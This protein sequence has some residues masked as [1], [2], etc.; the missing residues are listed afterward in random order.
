VNITSVK[1]K[2]N[3]KAKRLNLSP[4]DLM[5]MYFFERILYRIS[6]SEYKYN[7]IIKGGLLLSSMFEDE[8]RTTQDMDAMLKGIEVSKENLEKV[9]SDI[10]KIDVEDGITFEILDFRKIREE[11][12]YGGYRV[13]IKAFADKLSINLKMDIT[14]GDPI[15]PRE[16][17]YSYKC[18]ID[19]GTIKIMAF[20]KYSVIAEKFETL[21][22]TLETDTRAKDFYDIYKLMSD[23]IDREKVYKAIYS[24][25]KRR[26][27]LNLLED[28]E[29]R[30]NIIKE[31]TALKEYWHNYQ[32][33]NYYAKNVSYEDFTNSVEDIINIIISK[34]Q[35]A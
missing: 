21:F 13:S 11:D 19:E 12:L 23:D 1:T 22:E 26:N 4:Q 3:N 34:K 10:L 17:E 5:Q 28:L 18:L 31:S 14:T 25:F 9:L 6:I 20:S 33:K 15:I 27:A 24:T 29:D 16:I 32:R 2:I 30:L 8:S 7:F 35:P